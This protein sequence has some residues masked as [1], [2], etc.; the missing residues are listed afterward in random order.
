MFKKLLVVLIFITLCNSMITFAQDSSS[1]S[2]INPNSYCI[3]KTQAECYSGNACCVWCANKTEDSLSSTS[4]VGICHYV[5]EE[6]TTTCVEKMCPAKDYYQIETCSCNYRSD[7][8]TLS[9]PLFL[10]FCLL[11]SSLIFSYIKN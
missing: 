10:T 2:D 4:S 8:N 9:V 7:S 1:S 11:I 6:T 5:P 3:G